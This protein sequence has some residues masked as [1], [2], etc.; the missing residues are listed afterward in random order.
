MKNNKHRGSSF[1]SFLEEEGILEEVNAAALKTIIAHH[2]KAHMEKNN[3]TQTEM[4][5][6][7]KTSRPA[8][9]RL[10]D[11]KNYS[12]T[13]LTFNRAA[14]ILGKRININLEDVGQDTTTSKSK[15]K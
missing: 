1:D 12:V 15:S 3:I 4:A 8:L 11:P 10:L 9:K 14:S 13:L 2:L 6:L 7:L 5:K